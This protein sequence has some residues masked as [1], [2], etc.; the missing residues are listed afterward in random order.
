LYPIDALLAVL[1]A[2]KPQ[3]YPSGESRLAISR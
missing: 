1:V 2:L 3:L